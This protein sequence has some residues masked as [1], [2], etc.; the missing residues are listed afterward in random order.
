MNESTLRDLYIDARWILSFA[1]SATVPACSDGTQGGPARRP[2]WGL[3]TTASSQRCAKPSKG[4]RTRSSVPKHETLL[5]E[6]GATNNC[7]CSAFS[8]NQVFWETLL[9]ALEDTFPDTR[10][11]GLLAF[12]ISGSACLDCTGEGLPDGLP[13]D[14]CGRRGALKS[15]NRPISAAA[16]VDCCFSYFR[17]SLLVFPAEYVIGWIAR[18]LVQSPCLSFRTSSFFVVAVDE[19]SGSGHLTLKIYREKSPSAITPLDALVLLSSC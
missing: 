17:I 18:R 8:A 19:T 14:S 15:L 11:T 3:V 7:A 16:A 10:R 2:A 1:S 9:C 4:R 6:G 13:D 12:P 5:P